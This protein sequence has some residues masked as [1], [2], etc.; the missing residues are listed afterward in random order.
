MIWLSRQFS[1]IDH[2]Y[3]PCKILQVMIF[4][5]R[6]IVARENVLVVDSGAYS[7]SIV[8]IIDGN[9]IEKAVIKGDFGGEHLNE[10]LLD[11]WS[12]NNPKLN[13]NRYL[14]SAK[15]MPLAKRYGDIVI[16]INV[17]Q[18]MI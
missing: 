5:C 15:L 9:V 4:K 13:L 3:L 6:Y 12:K 14:N 11:I 1:S 10:K 8:P 17:F 18:M 7:T 2:N 16:D